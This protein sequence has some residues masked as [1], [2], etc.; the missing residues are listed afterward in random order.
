MDK[1]CR[2]IFFRP[3]ENLSLV[4]IAIDLFAVGLY[5]RV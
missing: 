2:K 4:M 1:V 5:Q 3:M